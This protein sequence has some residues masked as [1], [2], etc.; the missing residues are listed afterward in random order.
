MGC[1]RKA[2]L[3]LRLLGF[4]PLGLGGPRRGTG[5]D[6]ARLQEVLSPAQGLVLTI[7]SGGFEAWRLSV[8]GPSLDLETL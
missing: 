3:Q 5:G 6:P 7:R 8:S 4:W 1:F 2:R